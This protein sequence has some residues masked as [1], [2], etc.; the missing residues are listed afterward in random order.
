M[1][2]FLFLIIVTVIAGCSEKKAAR[3]KAFYNIDSLVSSQVQHLKGRYELNKYVAIGELKEE[4]VSFT[5]DSLQWANELDIF[6]LI[7]EVN[8]PAFRDRYD[9]TEERDTKSNLT[10]RSI[11]LRP[12]S[13]APVLGLKLYY[14]RNL[15]NLRKID[16]TMGTD[17]VLYKKLQSVVVDFETVNG[18]SLVQH[19]RIEGT[20]KMIMDDVVHFVIAGEVAM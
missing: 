7:D 8:K 6:R 14:L 1:R 4:K 10:V 16:A 13:Q 3:P 12:G 17:N 18:V 9:V 20:Q 15:T 11:Q 2:I 19:Y 5:P